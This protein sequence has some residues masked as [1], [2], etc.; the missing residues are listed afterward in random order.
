MVGSNAVVEK[1]DNGSFRIVLVNGKGELQRDSG[2]VG[3]GGRG[4]WLFVDTTEGR[5]I[6]F[7]DGERGGE[8]GKEVG[9]TKGR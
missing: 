7:G 5:R 3:R 6:W 4:L 1:V 8:G 9:L 2:G